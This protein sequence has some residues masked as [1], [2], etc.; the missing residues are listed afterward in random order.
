M[1]DQC[2]FA[3]SHSANYFCRF[4]RLQKKETKTS[5]TEVYTKLRNKVNYEEDLKKNNFKTTGIKEDSFVNLIFLCH[6]TICLGI[7]IMHDVFE[8]I[9]HYNLCEIILALINDGYCSL[10]TLNK[11]KSDLSY[12]EVE[13]GDKSPP[14]TMK[15]LQSRKLLMSASE[16]QCFAHHFPLIVGDLIRD[17]NYPVWKF[18][19][20]TIKFVDLLFLPFYTPQDLN[21]LTNTISKMNEMYITIF[22]TDLKPKHHYVTH[23][24]T[25]IRRFGPLYYI[26][27]MRY[28]A[29]HKVVK[30]YTKN[31]SSR[32]NLSHSLGKKLQYNFACRLLSKT[33]LVDNIHIGPSKYFRL[34]HSKFFQQLEISKG[35][36]SLLNKNL[37]ETKKVIVNGIQFSEKLCITLVINGV[38]TLFEIKKIIFV[39]DRISDIHFVCQGC[40]IIFNENFQCFEVLISNSDLKLIGVTEALK[41]RRHPVSLHTMDTNKVRFRNKSF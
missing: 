3:G 10:D 12:G 7:D 4:C 38:M 25:M 31:T 26:S 16:M 27:S 5:T 19:L 11:L 9:L 6:A 35:L 32:L 28:E 36:Q 23:Y 29:K 37:K 13:S 24:P 40:K 30:N 2:G 18:L 8:G 1:N 41:E 39:A 21:N 15:R 22:K 20:Q 33:G 34:E 17:K 14:I